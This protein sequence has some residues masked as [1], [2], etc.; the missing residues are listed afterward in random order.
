MMQKKAIVLSILLAAC[1]QQKEAVSKV[2]VH[3]GKE[4]YLEACAICHGVHGDGSGV[5][6]PALRLKPKS[7]SLWTENYD[8]FKLKSFIEGSVDHPRFHSAFDYRAV[9]IYS[10]STI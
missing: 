6:A 1:S 9:L 3:K 4:I 7:I 5:A 8:T 10:K 2:D